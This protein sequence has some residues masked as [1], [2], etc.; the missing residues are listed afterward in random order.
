VKRLEREETGSP[1]DYLPQEVLKATSS[2]TDAAQGLRLDRGF[3]LTHDTLMADSVGTSFGMEAPMSDS[4]VTTGK[5]DYDQH[6]GFRIAR[7]SWQS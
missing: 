5:D 3:R 6:L 4:V 1:W 2:M 7:D